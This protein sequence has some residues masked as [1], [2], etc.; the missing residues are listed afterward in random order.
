MKFKHS[1]LKNQ[2]LLKL[3]KLKKVILNDIEKFFEIEIKKRKISLSKLLL[4]DKLH[5]S[6]EGHILY[7]KRNLKILL[8]VIKKMN[9]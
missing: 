8:N 5:L 7:F 1:R 2:I 4:K 6:E 9:S 3:L